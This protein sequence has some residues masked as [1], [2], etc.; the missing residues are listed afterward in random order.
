MVSGLPLFVASNCRCRKVGGENR[1]SLHLVGHNY[2]G[3]GLPVDNLVLYSQLYRN[4]VSPSPVF[5]NVNFLFLSVKVGV[6]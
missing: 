3:K 6:A 4:Y 5:L 1:I 2:V